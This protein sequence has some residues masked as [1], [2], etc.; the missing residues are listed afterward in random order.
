MSDK[1]LLA[2]KV[3]I[4]DI[5]AV[6]KRVWWCL[7]RRPVSRAVPPLRRGSKWM[8]IGCSVFQSC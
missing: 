5:V 6:E 4:L 2:D 8:W 3:E 1:K 7:L